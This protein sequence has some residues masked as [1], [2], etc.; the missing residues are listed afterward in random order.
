MDGP[1]LLH[2]TKKEESI[3]GQYRVT[4]RRGI[5]YVLDGDRVVI[6]WAF[7]FERHDGSRF[8]L[9]EL[10]YQLWSGEQVVEEWFYYDPTQ[11]DEHESRQ[12]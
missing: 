7:E 2:L 8:I 4:G 11:R 9:N 1:A 3:L 5:T 10:A 6:N 12:R